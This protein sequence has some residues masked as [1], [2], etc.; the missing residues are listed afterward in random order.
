MKICDMRQVLKEFLY[1]RPDLKTIGNIENGNHGF[2]IALLDGRYLK[3]TNDSSEFSVCKTFVGKK[4]KFLCDVF[5]LGN[6]YSQ[7]QSRNYYSIVLEHLYKSE[8]QLWLNIAFKDFRHAWFSLFPSGIN[9]Y[10]TWSD[11]WNIYKRQ[12]HTKILRTRQL[13]YDYISNIN[14][15]LPPFEMLSLNEIN[16]RRERALFFFDFISKAYEELFISCPYGRIDLNEGNF[17]FNFEGE[18]KVLDMQTESE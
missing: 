18:I 8:K 15:E 11:L 16:I 12:E 9:D 13:L 17:M 14:D 7:S 1:V 10:I 3:I 5:E 4:N 2:A 6:F